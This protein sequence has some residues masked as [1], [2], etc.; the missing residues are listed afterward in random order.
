M[1]PRGGTGNR[2]LQARGRATVGTELE[3]LGG[4]DSNP[5]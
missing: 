4:E 1:G 5:E 3:E 2:S